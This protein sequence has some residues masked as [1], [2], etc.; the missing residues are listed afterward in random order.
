MS[1]IVLLSV[2]CEDLLSFH[3]IVELSSSEVLFGSKGQE[4]NVSGKSQHGATR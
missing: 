4:G 1:F 3:L 2:D